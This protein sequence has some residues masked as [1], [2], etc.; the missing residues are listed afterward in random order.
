MTSTPTFLAATDFSR[1]SQAA[2]DHA[3]A[4]AALVGARLLIVHVVPIPSLDA[5]EG[6]LHRGAEPADFAAATRELQ[7]IRPAGVRV[8]HHI[9]KGDPAEQILELAAAHEVS[10]IILGTNGRSGLLR[11]LLGSVAERVLK[12]A[13]CPVLTLRV[14]DA[15]S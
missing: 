2:V 1:S 3:A 13:R 5:G 8:E 10:L 12:A 4:H 6:L 7:A 14:P 11:A 15:L 9:T